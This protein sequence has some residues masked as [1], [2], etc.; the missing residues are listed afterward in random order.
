MICHTQDA[1][2]VTRDDHHAMDSDDP[3]WDLVL[4]DG[5]TDTEDSD[6]DDGLAPSAGTTVGTTSSTNGTTSTTMWS[7]PPALVSPV[8]PLRPLSTCCLTMHCGP[9]WGTSIKSTSGSS[10]SH[11]SSHKSKTTSTTAVHGPPEMTSTT[12]SL[13]DNTLSLSTTTTTSPFPIGLK[14]E[15]ATPAQLLRTSS[16]H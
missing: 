7:L 10:W 2:G 14:P 16:S 9:I 13:K 5:G 11:P 12:T 6:G 8:S 4:T 3:D 15:P 1:G